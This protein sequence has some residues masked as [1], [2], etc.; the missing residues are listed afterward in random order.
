MLLYFCQALD[1]L[2]NKIQHAIGEADQLLWQAD[3][4]MVEK[5]SYDFHEHVASNIYKTFLDEGG[6]IRILWQG[7]TFVSSRTEVALPLPPLPIST[8]ELRVKAASTH[9]NLPAVPSESKAMHFDWLFLET[10]RDV[11]SLAHV[12]DGYKHLFS[13]R[14]P[15]R[16]WTWRRTST[17]SIR[18]LA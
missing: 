16:L 11:C 18:N 15:F 6:D 3:D 17:S 4:D 14:Q 10:G 5:I 1:L 7:V 13:S 9:T 2:C 8:D 12:W